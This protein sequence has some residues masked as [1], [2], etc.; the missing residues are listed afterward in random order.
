MLLE[1]KKGCFYDIIDI[2]DIVYFVEYQFETP[3]GPAPI[4]LEEA[5]IDGID[6][7]DVGDIVYMVEYQFNGGPPPIDCP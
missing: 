3:S 1:L 2:A 7:V 6:G 5:D 4:C